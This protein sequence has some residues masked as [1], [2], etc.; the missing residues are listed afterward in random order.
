MKHS[1]LHNFPQQG[2]GQRKVV[3]ATIN[4]LKVLHTFCELLLN[5]NLYVTELKCS[6]ETKSLL[7]EPAFKI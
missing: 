7:S 6:W 3:T 5:S 4:V 1:R 2:Q